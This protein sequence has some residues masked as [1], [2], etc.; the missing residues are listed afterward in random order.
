MVQMSQQ[1]VKSYFNSRPCGRGDSFSSGQSKV[2]NQ[3]QFT[4][5]REGRPLLWACNKW[6]L[7]FQFTPLREGRPMALRHQR[8]EFFISIHAPAGGATIESVDKVPT[9]P[10]S[11]HAP[12]GGAT[13]YAR[14]HTVVVFPFQFTPLREGRRS[15][16]SRFIS[17]NNFNSR[18]CGRGDSPRP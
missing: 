6:L 7:A 4:P 17:I 14:L 5:L 15:S 2:G 16:P 10:I 9:N 1:Q 13:Q 18:P 3:F 12:A 8:V 11:I